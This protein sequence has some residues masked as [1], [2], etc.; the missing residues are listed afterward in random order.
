[1]Q[2]NKFTIV[3]ALV[4]TV[5]TASLAAAA[6]IA[7]QPVSVVHV[8]QGGEPVAAE[9]ASDGVIHL[10]YNLGD[11]P[12]YV[13]SSDRGATFTTPLPVVNQEARKQGLKFDSWS[14]AVGQA[15]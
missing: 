11:I 3:C 13:K 1:M 12:Y 15:G 4:A 14:V 10:L 2:L 6:T 7:G 9:I 5:A 8:P